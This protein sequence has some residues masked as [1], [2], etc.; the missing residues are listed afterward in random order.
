M[1]QPARYILDNTLTATYEADTRPKVATPEDLIKIIDPLI[2]ES[3]Q[4][5]IYT[6]ALNSQLRLISVTLNYIGT[7]SQINIEIK[8]ILRP[9]LQI[10]ADNIIVFHNH[11]G[12]DPKPSPE[13][14]RL[15]ADL[16]NACKL[17]ALPLLDHIVISSNGYQSIRRNKPHL[18]NA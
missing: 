8:D 1:T 14:E 7:N 13:D 12:G 9:A 2:V 15:T 18:W 3:R 4:E 17:L 6:V 11:P 16:I 10:E 5:R